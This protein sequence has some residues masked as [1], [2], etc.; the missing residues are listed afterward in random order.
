MDGLNDEELDREG[1]ENEGENGDEGDNQAKQEY[2]KK[3]FVAR[4]YYNPVTE[5]EVRALTTKNSR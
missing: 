2:I 3:E 4:P 5:N 1:S